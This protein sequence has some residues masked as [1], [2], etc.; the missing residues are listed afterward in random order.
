MDDH[1]LANSLRS[2]EPGAL[3]A[4]Y[5]AYAG[6]LYAYCWFRLLS[7][8]AARTAL[9]DAFIVARARI[10]QLRD[11]ERLGPWLYSIA[12]LECGRHPPGHVP[13]ADQPDVSGAELPELAALGRH[14]A[15]RRI[16]AWRGAMALPPLGRE[17]LDLRFR[18]RLSISDLAAVMGL[19]VAQAESIVDRARSD[20]EAAVAAEILAYGGAQGCPDRAELVRNRRGPLTADLRERLLRHARQ[21]EAC[22]A[23]RPRTVSVI[24]VYDLLPMAA[25]PAGLRKHVLNGFLDPK[26]IGY[27]LTV[28]TRAGPFA[29]SGFPAQTR[30]PPR[31]RRAGSGH[32]AG[33]ELGPAGGFRIMLGVAA[34][35]AFMIGLSLVPWFVEPGGQS[36]GPVGPR[37]APGGSGRTGRPAPPITRTPSVGRAEDV[38]SPA[39]AP[40]P[41]G[42]RPPVPAPR[43]MTV[44]TMPPVGWAPGPPRPWRPEPPLPEERPPPDDGPPPP[45]EGPPPGESAPPED[46][47]PSPTA[48]PSAPPVSESPSA[49]PSESPSAPPQEP[50]PTPSDP[51]PSATDH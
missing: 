6:R 21:C 24:K 40:F 46:P 26:Q 45:D 38:F 15:D 37:V 39:S 51:I 30:R 12:R 44:P 22:T 50:S 41:L 32:L 28:V 8:D 18:H 4:V 25:P 14:D 5:D 48:S 34:A 31:G 27:R 29:P 13:G 42:T 1:S 17:V 10:D 9:G 7:H 16:T 33:E 36:G 23:R 49:P 11:R 35:L 47:S 2:R 19:N 20:L 43:L 3:A